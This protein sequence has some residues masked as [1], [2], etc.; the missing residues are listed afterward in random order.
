MI[1]KLKK[2]ESLCE[3]WAVDLDETRSMFSKKPGIKYLL[4]FVDAFTK[5]AS[6][7]PLKKAK[8]ALNAFIKLVNQANH[9]PSKLWI[10]QGKE[11]YNSLMQE[12][13]KDNDI[14]IFLTHNKGKLVVA[15]V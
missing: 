10:V 7:K 13:L 11:I 14:E 12:W 9:H 5:Y 8:A 4:C 1:K 2:K 3:I 6:V 15:E